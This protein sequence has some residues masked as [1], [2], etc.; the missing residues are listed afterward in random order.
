MSAVTM[1]VRK[2]LKPSD[3][4]LNQMAFSAGL[5][6]SVWAGSVTLCWHIHRQYLSSH[7]ERCNKSEEDQ[8]HGKGKP[9]EVHHKGRLSFNPF[10]DHFR[11]Y[12]RFPTFSK[13]TP[14]FEQPSLKAW[15]PILPVRARCT[16]LGTQ[17]ANKAIL[18]SYMYGKWK[19]D[20]AIWEAA[21]K[22]ERRWFRRLTWSATP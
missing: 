13:T 20:T 8:N 11:T 12:I 17:I 6:G 15:R 7:L 10:P 9:L 16:S 3:T 21:Y 14:F 5:E 4:N 22:I 18:L 2:R 19:W 1:G